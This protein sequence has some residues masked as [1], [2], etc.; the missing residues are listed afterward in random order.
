MLTKN[1]ISLFGLF[2]GILVFSLFFISNPPQG[3]DKIAWLTAGVAALMTIWWL[4]EA[5]PIYATGLVPLLFFPLLNLFEL[6]IVATS[7]AH[8]LVLLFLGGFIIASAMEDSGLHKR[9]AVKI[10]SFF[11]TSPS[12][13]IGGFMITTAVL[14]MWVS[15]TASTIMMLPIATSVIAF[16]TSQ[17]H[18]EDNNF[19]IPLLLSIAYA[20]S[21]GGTATLIGTPTN[22]MLASILSDS[23]GYKISFID[24]LIIGLPVTVILIPIVWFFLTRIIFKVSL[25]KSYALDTTLVK[26]K[27]EIGKA[28][29]T[30]KVVALVF[31][32][33]A[34]LWIL[35]KTLNE[36]FNIALNDTSIGIFGALLL[37]IIPYGSNKRACNWETANKIPW[38]VLF[39]VGG[40]IALSRAIKTSGLAEW[41]GSFSNYLYG[42]DI[43]LLIFIS[44]ALI[45]LLTELNSN[46]ATVATFTPILIIFAIGLKVNP[47][48][49]VIPSTIAASCAFMLPIATPPNAVVFGSGKLKVSNMIKAGFPL[50]I[51]S[52]FVVT[53]VSLIIL[54]QIFNYEL[55]SLPEWVVKN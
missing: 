3:L 54:N 16:F 17:K 55:M 7:Y 22:I 48:I 21:I 33:T 25:E 34:T 37:F 24:W 32:L 9:I 38:G 11:G 1:N 28:S 53:S 51:I 40:G 4:T 46:T 12:K 52:I 35:R 14:S 45:I 50:N 29:T 20:A 44:V 36:N 8:P 23:Y 15:N 42:L 27:R 18:V 39:L 41:I 47:L 10:L 31:F 19:A 2:F 30:E 49:F 26:M 13:I 5:I 43:Y 6:K